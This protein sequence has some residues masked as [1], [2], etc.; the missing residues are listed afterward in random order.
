MGSLIIGMMKTIKRIGVVL[1]EGCDIDGGQHAMEVLSQSI[2]LDTVVE[3]NQA[4]VRKQDP[5]Y[6]DAVTDLNLRLNHE[7]KK[8]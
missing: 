5:L 2:Q 3:V 8:A 4:L 6:L 1:K 7:L